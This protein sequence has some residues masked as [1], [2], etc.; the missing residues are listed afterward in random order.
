MS[1]A[2][3]D[4]VCPPRTVFAAYNRYA[5]PEKEMIVYPYA[6]HVGGG[7]RQEWAKLEWVRA[8]LA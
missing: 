6:W 7:Q 5:G 2:L 1:V 4:N 3:M 8:R